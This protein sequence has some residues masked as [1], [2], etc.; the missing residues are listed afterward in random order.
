MQILIGTDVEI[1][2]RGIHNKKLIPSWEVI[3]NNKDNPYIFENSDLSNYTMFIDNVALEFNIPPA[4]NKAEFKRSIYIAISYIDDYLTD[5]CINVRMETDFM[6]TLSEEQRN[7]IKSME[8]NCNPDYNAWNNKYNPPVTNIGKHRFSGGH[9]HIGARF[10]SP[11]EVIRLVKRLDY[12]LGLWSV[13]Q[14]KDEEIERRKMYG[15]AGDFR[16]KLYGLEYRVLS[17]FWIFDSNFID[18]VYDRTMMAVKDKLNIDN[19]IDYFKDDIIDC[20]NN[21]DKQKAYQLTN[22]IKKKC[23]V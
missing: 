16:P 23:V 10:D 1:F 12:Y 8:F 20:I 5:R 13:S 21:V 14:C 2:L 19:Q 17:N 7:N 3:A 9:V 22:E 18:E 15:R 11:D 6:V 4:R